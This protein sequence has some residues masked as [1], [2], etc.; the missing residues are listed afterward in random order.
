[1]HE[2]WESI[3]LLDAFSSLW[4]SEGCF[5]WWY[6]H[7]LAV[8]QKHIGRAKKQ[9]SPPSVGVRKRTSVL[10]GHFKT[11]RCFSSLH[12]FSTLGHAVASCWKSVSWRKIHRFVLKRPFRTSVLFSHLPPV[13]KLL[14]NN[15]FLFQWWFPNLSWFAM[16][17]M[18]FF[19]SCK[20]KL[21]SLS[22]A[23]II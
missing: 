15:K 7:S 21:T 22:I 4:L 23:W 8:T 1:M 13:V 18:T 20:W 3:L 14:F 9:S 11:Q 17:T 12:S 5:F 6:L 19:C 10:H 16:I 2:L